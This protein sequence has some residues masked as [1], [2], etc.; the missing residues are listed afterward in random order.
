MNST[1]HLLAPCLP[2]LNSPAPLPFPSTTHL[3]LA[4]RSP[5]L[6]PLPRP[7][8]TSLPPPTSWR[9]DP[10]CEEIWM[11]T[12]ASGMSSELSPTCDG[13]RS[14]VEVRGVG[15]DGREGAC[16]VGEAE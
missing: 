3:L 6:N 10:A 5:D 1:T 7:Y 16:R 14:G 12:L 9:R 13:A 15:E 4:P 11:S 8:P 2:I